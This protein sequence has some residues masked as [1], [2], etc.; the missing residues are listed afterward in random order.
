[1]EDESKLANVIFLGYKFNE[2]NF[3]MKETEEN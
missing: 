1:M 3:C 2:I